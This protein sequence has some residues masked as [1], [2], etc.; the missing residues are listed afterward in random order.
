MQ[1]AQDERGWVALV[2]FVVPQAGG[3]LSI[4]EWI[5]VTGLRPVQ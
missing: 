2:T 4:Q 1:G 3:D 5:H